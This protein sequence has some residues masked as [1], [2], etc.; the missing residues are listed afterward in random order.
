MG[1]DEQKDT[2]ARVDAMKAEQQ[3]QMNLAAILQKNLD[4][5]TKEGKILKENTKS[6]LEASDLES[7]LLEIA[8]AKDEVIDKIWDSN[9]G[10]AKTM[11]EQLENAEKLAKTEKKIRDA[12]SEIKDIGKDFV[13]DLANSVGIS[14]ELADALMKASKAAIVL[15]ILKEV[16]SFLLDSFNNAR[17]FSKE[18]GVSAMNAAGM[19]ANI[20]LARLELIGLGYD[21]D[22]VRQSMSDIVEATGMISVPPKTLADVTKLTSLLGDSNTA[23][24]LQRTLKNAGVDAGALTDSVTEMA[25]KLGMDAGPAMEYLASNQLELGGLTEQQILKRAEEG[26]MLKKMGADMKELNRLASESLDIETSLRN[27]MK[28]RM[29]TGKEINL[30]ELRAAQA[31]GDVVALGKAQANLVAQLGDDLHNNLQVQRMI[32]DATGMSTE[33]LLNYDNASK[34]NAKTQDELLAIKEKYGLADIDQ[35]KTLQLQQASMKDMLT[36]SG[37]VVGGL[38]A[39]V[40]LMQVLSPLMKKMLPGG[41]SKKGNPISNFIKSMGSKQVLMG[42]AAMLIISASLMVTAK[43]L[44]EF[45]TVEWESLGMAGLALLGLVGS[46]AALGAV[47]MSGIGAVAILAGAAALLTIAGS[48]VVLGAG[49]QLIGNN[50]GSLENLVPMLSSLVLLSPGLLA[51]SGSLTILSGSLLG[52]SVGLAAV[53]VFLPVLGALSNIGLIGG[54]GETQETD[55]GMGELLDEVKGLRRDIQTQPIMINVDGKVV[56]AISKVQSRQMSV[57]TTGYGR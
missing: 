8:K 57:N 25:N 34:E 52:L 26:L 55:N 27:E 7:K 17:K 19:E 16:A 10:L 12:T 2:R 41:D 40:G 18:L 53:S 44:N 15:V 39:M 50:I 13:K 35:A 51:L 20:Q 11:L 32:S 56:S 38:V 21:A 37:M 42:A 47:M 1:K 3:I 4:G 31:S 22:E 29:M 43:A 30:N 5:R 36:T 45:N 14:N 24:S 49:I 46:V 28:L 23:V 9:K 6:I 48:M 33:Q 54:G